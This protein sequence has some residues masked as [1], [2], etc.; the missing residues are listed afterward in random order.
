[1]QFSVR[2]AVAEKFFVIIVQNAIKTLASKQMPFPKIIPKDQES[3]PINTGRS[4]KN[5]AGMVFGRLTAIKPLRSTI[6]GGIMWMCKCQCGNTIEIVSSNL[7]KTRSCG[8]LIKEG[9]IKMSTKHGFTK[10]GEKPVEY[11]I[12]SHIK[13]R[14]YNPNATHYED[15]GGRGIK[16]CR[17][18]L[19]SFPNFLED[20]GKRPDGMTIE[21]INSNGNYNPKKL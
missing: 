18:W 19:N 3:I 9:L 6:P 12:W 16:M 13:E 14:C 15:Y 5:R 8:C 20:M 21:R 4:F 11:R 17:R 1:M 10:N 2:P 7:N